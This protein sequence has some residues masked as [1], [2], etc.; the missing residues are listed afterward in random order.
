MVSDLAG[1]NYRDAEGTEWVNGK[2]TGVLASTLREWQKY[3]TTSTVRI[4]KEGRPAGFEVIWLKEQIEERK[5]SR[6]DAAKGIFNGKS[7]EPCISRNGIRKQQKLS[8]STIYRMEENQVLMPIPLESGPITYQKADADPVIKSWKQIWRDERK[9]RK[10]NGTWPDNRY[11]IS[12]AA[13]ICNTPR[14][15]VAWLVKKRMISSEPRKPPYPY[16]GKKQHTVLIAEVRQKSKWLKGIRDQ[17]REMGAKLKLPANR[18]SQLFKALLAGKSVQ[19]FVREWEVQH[20]AEVMPPPPP[21][22]PKH[23][24]EAKERDEQSLTAIDRAILIYSRDPS[25]TVRA[26]AK[27]VGCSP[28]TLSESAAF[29]RLRDAQTESVTKGTKSKDGKIETKAD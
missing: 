18:R 29:Q 17:V 2:A 25:L 26:L 8:Y 5:Q 27:M 28:S 6:T 12:A 10:F 15:T 4:T 24:P 3:L 21:A 7:G 19:D 22:D 13:R 20:R 1:R 16:V 11:S 9:G 14:G 23:K